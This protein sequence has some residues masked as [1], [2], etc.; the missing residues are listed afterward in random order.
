MPGIESSSAEWEKIVEM[1]AN[2]TAKAI[3][4]LLD[5]VGR[6]NR[7]SDR[8]GVDR[9]GPSWS[10]DAKET[11]KYY[12]KLNNELKDSTK[13]QNILFKANKGNK[14]VT[15][16]VNNA[17][18]RLDKALEQTIK[19]K[20]EEIADAGRARDN[21]K[22]GDL[23][24]EKQQL[25]SKGLKD[26]Q[27]L[28][29]AGAEHRR[30]LAEHEATESLITFS[31]HVGTTAVAATGSFIKGLQS[32]SSGFELASGIMG[33]SADMIGSAGKTAGSAV[34]S[35]GTLI[36]GHTNPAVKMLGKAA[37]FAGPML[38]LVAEGASKL[39]KF[40]IEVLSKEVEKSV[41]A[42]GEA[43]SSGAM[44][45]DGLKGLRA[46]AG[47][48]GL[49]VG[50]FASVLSKH[51]TE[52]SSLGMGVT[53][54]A[55][56]VSGA[57]N[58]GGK[59]MKRQMLNLGYSFEDQAGLVAET[60]QK[61]RG[62]GGPLQASNAEVARQTMKYA[63]NLRI[64]SSIT[65]ED[66]KAKVAQVAEQNQILAFQ[67]KMAGKSEDQ[68]AAIDA[69]MV[70]MTEQEKKNFR[71]RVV[72]G[73]VINKEG[74]IY[75]A[76]IAGTREKGEAQ[77][78]L[79]DQNNLTAQTNADLNVKYGEQIKSSVLAQQDIGVAA[80]AVGG[81]LTGV[82]TAGLDVVNQANKYTKDGVA[83]GKAATKAQENTTDKFS[84]VEVAA[85]ELRVALQ[86]TLTPAMY[87]FADVTKSVL[88][89]VQSMVN[90]AMGKDAGSSI[91]ED[92]TKV[93]MIATVLGG[94]VTGLGALATATG[95]GAAV[96]VPMMA[97]GTTMMSGGSTVAAV[98]GGA[99]AL[100]FAKGGIASGP[101]SGFSEKLHGTE[102]II[103][104][105]DGKSVPV[106]L[107]GN[108]TGK[109]N[110]PPDTIA[111]ITTGFLDKLHN[112]EL[113]DLNTIPKAMGAISNT[114]LDKLHNIELPDL[115]TIPNAIE[116]VSNTLLD[117]MN[118][119]NNAINSMTDQE[120][121]A[122]LD[123]PKS[124]MMPTDLK[125]MLSAISSPATSLLAHL[126][127]SIGQMAS[128]NLT[129]LTGVATASEGAIYEATM[130][131]GRLEKLHGTDAMDSA[132]Y[133]AN[134]VLAGLAPQLDIASKQSKRD[135]DL[136]RD[137]MKSATTINDPT[138]VLQDL[139]SKQ[140]VLMQKSLD[141]SSEMLSSMND[142]RDIQQSLLNV[143][144]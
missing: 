49:D 69:A 86:D 67:Q 119:T 133:T 56:R 71:D 114:L 72:L 78:R 80:Y 38:G 9:S 35:I 103:P 48:A 136:A 75:E 70:T 110:A 98:G 129:V 84:D 7:S 34:G 10:A 142:S 18:G 14:S 55:K 92:V 143:S 12:N 113:P 79:L 17:L 16:Q 13:I 140:L 3:A 57:L 53:E 6:M 124:G 33:A 132:S 127:P 105:P 11:I 46:A 4:P 131:S 111:S 90:T 85:Q 117:K 63:E 51:S 1:Q 29:D 82:A 23:Q 40:G 21:Q 91:A 106:T 107:S 112:I 125:T 109:K 95:F 15:E 77:K 65:G 83:A 118:G 96:G 25:A 144:Y 42:F 115:N 19:R 128:D 28:I 59:D 44:F 68:R 97:A 52:L 123:K 60:M 120:K 54:G 22:I 2:A 100:G 87:K 66:A 27:E 93:G 81:V 64:I 138:N 74:A 50:Q 62:A 116:S 20:D 31:K 102:A 36:K 73:T 45:A 89:S 58:S 101:D 61:M 47:I 24:L 99:Q 134:S 137:E 76:T 94:V 30:V 108:D 122:A 121:K 139:L 126:I 8:P 26:R 141:Q 41:K 5:A 104:L 88:D 135:I 32:G 39:A 130:A 37:E 43:S